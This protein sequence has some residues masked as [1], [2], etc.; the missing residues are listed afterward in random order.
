[1]VIQFPPR[2]QRS[3]RQQQLADLYAFSEEIL[4]LGEQGEWKQALATQRIRRENM[5][6]F[7]STPTSLEDSGLVRQVIE[8]I[9][10]LDRKVSTML[11]HQR[12]ELVEEREQQRHNGRQLGEYVRHS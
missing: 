1:M 12:S 8:A 2:E 3:A 9:L 5:D 4:T 7:F 11:Y 6:A 10:E